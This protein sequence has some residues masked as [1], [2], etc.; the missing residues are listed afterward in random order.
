[1]ESE[2]L[3]ARNEREGV[4][5]A[6]LTLNRPLKGN[7]LTLPMLD[8]IEAH[9][10]GVAADPAIRALVIRGAGK[11][12]CTGGDITAWGALSPGAMAQQWIHRGIDVIDRIAALPQPVVAVISGHALGGGLE[13]ALAADFRIGVRDAKL[14]TPEVG[15]GMIAGWGGVRRLAENI[16]LPRARELTL[17]GAPITAQ[18]AHEWGLLMSVADDQAALERELQSLLGKLL[19]NAP[20]AMR[21]TKSLLATMALDLRH[22]HA[23]AVEQVAATADCAEGVASFREKRKPVFKNR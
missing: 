4:A 8:A 6:E 23:V 18:Q 5:W 13:L 3:F 11:Y 7:A 16:G 2:I 10:A 15:I 21:A 19:A 9:V 20:I 17:I 1:M 12:F 22:Q 14:G